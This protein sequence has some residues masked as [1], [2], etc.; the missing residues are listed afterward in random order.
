MALIDLIEFVDDRGDIIVKRIPEQGSGEFRMGAQLVVR[1]SQQ[2][3]FFR[4]GKAYDTFGPGRHTLSTQ[5]IPLLVKAF[6]LPFGKSPFRA[7]VYFVNTR[8]FT[9]EKWGTVEAIPFQDVQFH[10]VR[11]RAYGKFSFRIIDAQIFV[12]KVVGVRGI[13]LNN[14]I[15]RFIS[16]I[17][18]SRFSDFLGETQHDLL[19]L[20]SKY[21]E[22]STGVK[23]RLE[24]D[25]SKYGIEI[26]D[27]YIVAITPPEE[28]Q[29]MIDERSGMN[30]VG[31]MDK[32]MKYKA[33]KSIEEAA[34]NPSGGGASDG[35]GMGAGLGMGF[36][37]AGMLGQAFSSSTN[38]KVVICPSCGAKN[39]ADAKFCQNCGKPLSAKQPETIDCPYCKAQIPKDSKFCPN[40][41]KPLIKK[42]P[43]CGVEV[44]ADAKFCPNCGKPI[45]ESK[46]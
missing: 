10:M 33:A 32:Y 8:A 40:C 13:F 11:L 24:E 28:V 15:E 16:E 1:E 43:S 12:N 22:I 21:D 38:Q 30:A 44:P 41:G 9:D 4:D 17:I 37:M 29:K 20:A 39:P 42:C 31:D 2:A 14:Q 3:V 18:V 5:N 36:G 6:A 7:E 34:K 19:T 46:E 35:M 45:D 23:A 27:F 25:M 26:I